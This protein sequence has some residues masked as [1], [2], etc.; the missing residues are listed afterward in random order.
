MSLII[1]LVTIIAL[2][3]VIFYKIQKFNLNIEYHI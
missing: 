2:F 1:R 3:F